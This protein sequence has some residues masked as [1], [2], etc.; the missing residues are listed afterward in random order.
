MKKLVFFGFSVL[1]FGLI[2]IPSTRAQMMGSQSSESENIS[3]TENEMHQTLNVVL[4]EI[5]SKYNV[6]RVQDLDCSEVTDEDFESVGEAVMETIHPGDVHEAMDE[7]MGGEGSE[8][9]REAHINM[10]EN[11]LG[12]QSESG[13]RFGMMGR[14]YDSQKGGRFGMMGWGYGA[15]M[16]GASNLGGFGIFATLV[17]IVVLVDLVL[18]GIWL[19]K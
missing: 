15:N 11:Y 7:R 17:W 3:N 9:L 4:S 10:G 19:W 5:L 1:V 6:S 16:M 13:T 14:N 18:L 12:C 2:F 8:S